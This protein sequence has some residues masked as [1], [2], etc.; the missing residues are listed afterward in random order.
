MGKALTIAEFTTARVA[1]WTVRPDNRGTP[2]VWYRWHE[3]SALRTWDMLNEGELL[4]RLRPEDDTRI[5]LARTTRAEP[6]DTADE[7][8]QGRHVADRAFGIARDK[9]PHAPAFRSPTC[10]D[11]LLREATARVPLPSSLWYELVLLRRRESGR[12]E[13][14][15]QQLFLPE[16]RRGDTRPFT[17]RCE[18]S[19]ENGTAFAVVTR[20]AAFSFE[21]LFLASG[22]IPPGTYNVTATLLRP[23]RVRFDGL[24]ARLREDSRN[25]LDILAALPDS[26]EVIGPAHLIIAIELC[27]TAETLRA[28]LDRASQLIGQVRSGADGLV[29]FSLVTYAAHSQE[30]RTID[31]PVTAHAWTETAA[32][33]LD[34]RLSAL[35][36]RDPATS[37][38]PDAA[39]VECMLAEVTRRLRAPEAAAAGRPVL[40]TIGDRPPFP[41]RIDPSTGILPCPKR[42]DWRVLLRGLADDYAGM[43]FGVIRD[44]ADDDPPA[45]PAADIWRQLGTDARAGLDTFDARRFAVDLGLLSARTQNL[46][47]PLAI[48]E[49][50][51]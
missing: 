37:R 44:V 18:A 35:R 5:V 31:E 50:A 4:D 19:D 20:D 45:S 27:G 32:G 6:G 30:R 49:G 25:W 47:L 17:V 11:D 3:W 46:P 41:H 28:R 8:G 42:Q 24:P 2:R 12:L 13:L 33:P 14:T 40:V 34:S 23:G 7:G 9:Y 15:A 10:V 51:D 1:V 39:P 38:Y 48:F 22:R 26:L 16:A 43:A 21:L 29:A 36:A